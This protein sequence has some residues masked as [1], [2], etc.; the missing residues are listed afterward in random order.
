MATMKIT[1]LVD[2][3]ENIH[4]HFETD[5]DVS[6]TGLL[7]ERAIAGLRA[8]CNSLPDTHWPAHFAIYRYWRRPVP[9]WK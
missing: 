1:V 6:E 5:G 3:G 4:S 7:L 8:E 2:G 9:Q